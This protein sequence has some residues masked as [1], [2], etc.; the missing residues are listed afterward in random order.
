MRRNPGQTMIGF[1]LLFMGAFF[2][3][4]NHGLL[5]GEAFLL[6]LGLAFVAA[7]F[8][9]GRNVALLIPGTV[10]V[11]VGS[12]AWLENMRFMGFRLS[13][14]W[15]FIFLG[16]AFA[17][18]FIIDSVGRLE[19]TTWAIYPAAALMFFGFFVLAVDVLPRNW[20]R[21]AG[22]WWPAVLI[23]LGVALI[24]RPKN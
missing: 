8:C 19:P 7:Y 1:L 17:L 2:L 16:L 3:L 14:G 18:V 21:L 23:L 9:V 6:F 10:L 5:R 22:V 20:W 13:G 24:L 15:F 12:F 11:A 4:S